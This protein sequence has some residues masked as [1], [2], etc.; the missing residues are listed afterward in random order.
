MADRHQFRADWHAYNEGIYFVTI[1]CAERRHY[2]GEIRDNQ[3]QLSA[4]GRIA[5]NQIKNIQHHFTD[6]EIWNYVVMPNH[7]HLVIA[8]GTLFKASATQTSATQTSATQTSATQT[9]ATQ[10]STTQTSTTQTSTTQTSVNLGCLKPRRHNAPAT[11]DF[12]HNHRLSVIIRCLKGGVKR[13]A[14]RATIDFSWQPRYHEHIIRDQR[15]Y[16]NIM[17]Y[18]DNNV[19]NWNQDCFYAKHIDNADALKSVPTP[20]P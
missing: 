4:L 20:T 16:E 11:Q 10:T 15:A 18:I 9:S 8:V 19:F 1:C 3:M 5:E 12:H 13:D 7:V 2:F 6:V 14:T 17:N